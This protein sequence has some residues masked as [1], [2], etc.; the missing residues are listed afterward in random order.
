MFH[1]AHAKT[2]RTPQKSLTTRKLRAEKKF[3]SAISNPHVDVAAQKRH[4]HDDLRS[5]LGILGQQN[6]TSAEG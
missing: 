5:G 6:G 4:W 3:G 2:G 1:I